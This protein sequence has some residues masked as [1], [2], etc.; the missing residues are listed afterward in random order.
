MP[1][2]ARA[3]LVIHDDCLSP[4]RGGPLPGVPYIT[5]DY[6]GPNPQNIYHKIKELLVSIWKVDASEIQERDFVWDRSK[7]TEKFR[8]RFEVIK[9]LDR[10]SFVHII[11]RLNGEAKPSKEF[12]KEGKA[13]IRIEGRLR[14]EYPQDTLW[15]RSLLY[16]MARVFYHRVFYEEKRKRYL[17]DCRVDISRFITDLKSFLAILSKHA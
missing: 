13:T 2:F 8:V 6:S 12:G 7:G 17:E 11:V 10:F 15:Q 1:I 4:V 14:T 16:E 9:D 5:L 3:K